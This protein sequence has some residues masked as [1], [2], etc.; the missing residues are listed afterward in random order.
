[1]QQIDPKYIKSAMKNRGNVY[2]EYG[3]FV[4]AKVQKP[5]KQSGIKAF[6]EKIAKKLSTQPTKRVDQVASVKNLVIQSKSMSELLRM[7]ESAPAAVQRI[8]QDVPYRSISKLD[9][10]IYGDNLYVG[11]NEKDKTYD[12]ITKDGVVIGNFNMKNKGYYKTSTR[13]GLNVLLPKEASESKDRHQSCEPISVEEIV[14]S[15]CAKN[16]DSIKYIPEELLKKFP[17]LEQF[18][19][20]KVA[21]QEEIKQNEQQTEKEPEVRPLT[22]DEL[23]EGRKEADLVV[24]TTEVRKEVVKKKMKD[25]ANKQYLSQER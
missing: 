5:K 3:E 18:I 12:V 4:D 20:K 24:Q 16:Q 14:G 10:N 25:V 21:E 2:V 15:Y 1:M 8:M 9:T 19:H 17:N 11:L 6:F 23:I 22:D 7:G 13:D